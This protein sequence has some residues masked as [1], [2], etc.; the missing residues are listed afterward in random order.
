[1]SILK[2]INYVIKKGVTNAFRNG[3][4]YDFPERD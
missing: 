1:M 3:S 4:N 2:C